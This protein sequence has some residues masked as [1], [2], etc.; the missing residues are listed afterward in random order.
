MFIDGI[1]RQLF[2][3]GRKRDPAARA[4]RRPVMAMLIAGTKKVIKAIVSSENWLD[5]FVVS[6][7]ASISYGSWLVYK[8][9][10]F[11]VGGLIVLL[12][13]WFHVRGGSPTQ[14]VN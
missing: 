9:A 10:G 2:S 11:I 14:G 3:L 13:C 4:A 12:F 5:V 7:I 8:P 6:A 1:S